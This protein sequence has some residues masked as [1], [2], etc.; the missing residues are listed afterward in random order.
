MKFVEMN[1]NPSD[2]QLRQFGVGALVFL[3]VLG[4]IWSSSDLVVIGSLAVL[5]TLLAGLSWIRPRWVQPVFVALSLVTIP[6]G[7]VIS[8]VT[9]LLLFIGLFYPIGIVF[10][11]M[12][13]DALQLCF[14]RKSSTYWQAKKQPAGPDSYYRQW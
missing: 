6:I 7:L 13:R 10:R 14:I 9:L 11:L 2:R 8:E 12:R 3:P 1:W 4:V 5:G